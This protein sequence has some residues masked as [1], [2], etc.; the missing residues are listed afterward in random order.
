MNVYEENWPVFQSFNLFSA[1]IFASHKHPYFVCVIDIR[2][3]LRFPF[4]EQ[5]LAAMKF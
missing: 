2:M 1:L 5:E 4:S 3:L